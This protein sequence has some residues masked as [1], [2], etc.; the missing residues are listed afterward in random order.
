MND[1]VQTVG[2]LDARSVLGGT[3]SG[4]T[5][6]LL[7]RYRVRLTVAVA[8]SMLIFAAAR[9]ITIHRPLNVRDLDSVIGFSLIASGCAIRSWAA[10]IL[11][12]NADLAM[13][14]PYALGE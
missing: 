4:R 8:V 11:R 7:V 1:T 13:E 5:S 10:G 2:L 14:G 12:K 9:G 6:A 3:E